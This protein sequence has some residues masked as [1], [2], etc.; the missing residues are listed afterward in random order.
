MGARPSKGSLEEHTMYTSL[1]TT[2]IT[3]FALTLTFGCDASQ[4]IADASRAAEEGR[5]SS[6]TRTDDRS[7]DQSE[8]AGEAPADYGPGHF[9]AGEAAGESGIYDE[10]VAGGSSGALLP[11]GR[12]VDE[13]AGVPV[14]MIDCVV[15]GDVARYHRRG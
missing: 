14:T 3:L 11:T 6:D 7:R 10:D 5:D 13:V 4:D 12:I 1:R 2:L 8:L 15:F 9:S